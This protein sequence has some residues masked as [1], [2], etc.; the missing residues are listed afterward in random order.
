[1]KRLKQLFDQFTLLYQV[2]AASIEVLDDHD[3]RIAALENKRLQDS[4]KFNSLDKRYSEL[5]MY[6]KEINRKLNSK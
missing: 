1:M 2:E 3:D 6:I 5:L 4:A